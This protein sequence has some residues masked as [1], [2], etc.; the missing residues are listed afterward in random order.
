MAYL[1]GRLPALD[2]VIRT[3]TV[4]GHS[5]EV[6]DHADRGERTNI[7]VRVDTPDGGFDSI[8]ADDVAALSRDRFVVGSQWSVRTF[9]D[10][11][12]R[13]F[14]AEAHDDVLRSGY[15]LDGVRHPTEHTQ[16]FRPRPGSPLRHS[17]W[18][19]RS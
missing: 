6:W 5:T 9:V 7:H 14:L 10:I 3:A 12:T 13:V 1:D 15:H 11:T 19:K 4:T 16:W 18:R 8:L 17:R 2:P